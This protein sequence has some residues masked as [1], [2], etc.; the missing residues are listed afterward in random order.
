MQDGTGRREGPEAS[1]GCYK[2]RVRPS[3]EK[4]SSQDFRRREALSL[5]RA[6]TLGRAF[7]CRPAIVADIDDFFVGVSYTVLNC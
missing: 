6:C 7:V 2:E 4:S 5:G 3:R 1:H